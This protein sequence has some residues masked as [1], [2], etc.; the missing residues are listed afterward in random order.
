[1]KN[2]QHFLLLAV[3]AMMAAGCN[4][5]YSP[6][7][8]D[9]FLGQK[10][11]C[12]VAGQ[13]EYIGGSGTMVQSS[14]NASKY[15]YRGGNVEQDRDAATGCLVD[16]INE[17]FVLM[18]NSVPGEAGTKVNGS[19]YLKHKS[20]PNSFRTYG[21]KDKPVEFEVLKVEEGKAWLWATSI[22]IGVVV[23]TSAE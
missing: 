3:L 2:L 20:L 22:K 17:Y 15:L 8:Q 19:L 21:S 18:L 9:V 23:R 16:I 13:K 4:P 10:D 14:F 11:I 1:M 7:N 5:P 6:S 12:M